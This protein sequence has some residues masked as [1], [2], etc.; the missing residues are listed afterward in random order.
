M[1]DLL[2]PFMVLWLAWALGEALQVRN[3]LGHIILENFYWSGVLLLGYSNYQLP[4]QGSVGGWRGLPLHSSLG[5]HHWLHD[6]LRCRIGETTACECQDRMSGWLAQNSAKTY[7]PM[8]CS[9]HFKEKLEVRTG[10]IYNV[11]HN[12]F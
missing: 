5:H 2:E 7:L 10:Y 12:L 3:V 8:F 6:V 1:K 9:L 4:G 11:H